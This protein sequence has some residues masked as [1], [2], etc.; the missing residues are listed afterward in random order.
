MPLGR[1]VALGTAVVALA[2]AAIA[3]SWL[4]VSVPLA[5]PDAIV[6]LA[7]HEWERLPVTASAAAR[8]PAAV[9]L[10]TRPERLTPFNCDDC[11]HRVDRL[12]RMGVSRERTRVLQL[13]TGGTWGEAQV[14][15]EAYRGLNLHR[16][17]VVTSPYHTRRAL[18]IFRATFDGSGVTVGIEPAMDHSPAQPASWWMAPYDRAYVAYEWAAIVYYGI[19]HGILP[20]M[21]PEATRP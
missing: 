4:V 20:V 8:Y 17:L 15:R 11:D 10:L 12:V 1:G 18:S 13:T 14:V 9:V 6:A 5:A 16:L 2:W 19:R 7:S 21:D 3:G